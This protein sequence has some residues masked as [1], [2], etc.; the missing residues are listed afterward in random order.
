MTFNCHHPVI[1]ARHYLA[2]QIENA[3]QSNRV[4]SLHTDRA[5]LEAARTRQPTQGQE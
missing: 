3:N 4:E 1:I 5:S 2:M